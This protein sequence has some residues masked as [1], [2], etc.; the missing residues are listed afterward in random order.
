M[1]KCEKSGQYS[2]IALDHALLSSGLD[3][4]D[5]ALTAT[6]VY[7][8]IERKITLDYYISMLSSRPVSEIEPSVLMAVRMGIYQLEYLDRIPAHAAINESVALCPAKSRGFVNAILRS[9]VRERKKLTLP[10]RSD[11]TVKYLSVSYSVGEELCKRFLDIFGEEKTENIL[12]ATLQTPPLTLRVNTLKIDR[13]QLITKLG[14][15]AKPSRFSPVGITT[16]G[17]VTELYGFD[18][19]LFFIQDEASQLCTAA[20]GAREGETVIDACSCPGSKSFG[21]AI[22]M[23]N[24]GSVLSF[25]LHGNKLSLVE[26]SAARLGINIIRTGVRDGKIFDSS[27]EKSAD[28]VLCDVPCSGFGVIAKKPE[29]RYKDPGESKGLC[30]IQLDILKNNSR[31]VRSGGVLVYSTCTLLPEENEGNI[32]RFLE[33]NSDFEPEAFRAGSLECDGMMTLTPD[34]HGTDG[35]F[36]CRMRRK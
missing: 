6:L 31:Y 7:G 4:S 5:R 33:S 23:N 17:H 34:V 28:R 27:L 30:D 12:K 36:I 29:L 32:R 19:G 18:E 3:T 1:L 22:D 9:F 10:E 35:F 13:E 24:K 2:N 16:S 21:T 15:T 11:G 8:V 20:L 25:D 26:S 14:N